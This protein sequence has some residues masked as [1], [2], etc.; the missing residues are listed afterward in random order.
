MED[1]RK[2]SASRDEVLSISGIKSGTHY[3]RGIRRVTYSRHRFVSARGDQTYGAQ[4]WEEVEEM[5]A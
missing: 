2:L 4:W 1:D 5:C 3:P